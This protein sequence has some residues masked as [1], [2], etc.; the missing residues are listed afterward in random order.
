M[1]RWPEVWDGW[2]RRRQKCKAG[3][4]RRSAVQK[5]HVVVRRLFVNIGTMPACG[6]SGQCRSSKLARFVYRSIKLACQK[7]A[8]A[9]VV[10]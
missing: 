9:G 1:N 3:S 5:Y 7:V 6:E 8:R 4:F 2:F 10:D